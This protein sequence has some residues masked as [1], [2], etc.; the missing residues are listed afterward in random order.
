MR[1]Y[2]SFL[3]VLLLSILP[4]TN[5][6]CQV[7]GLQ[8]VNVGIGVYINQQGYCWPGQS[9]PAP[10]IQISDI[11]LLMDCSDWYIDLYE[12]EFGTKL[13]GSSSKGKYNGYNTFIPV[14]FNPSIETTPGKMYTLVPRGSGTWYIDN[15]N[16]YP[17]GRLAGTSPAGGC[18]GA[19]W[20]A[21][22]RVNCASSSQPT[23]WKCYP[24]ID[25]PLRLNAAGDVEC[26]AL[27][28]ANCLWTSSGNCEA[29][30]TG[31]MNSQLS[32]LSCGAKHLS[33]YGSPGY[34]IDAHWC[35]KG[36]GFMK[37]F[38]CIP[39]LTSPFRINAKGNPECLSTNAADCYWGTVSCTSKQVYDSSAIANIKP[40]ACGA[41][42]KAAWGRTGYEDGPEHWCNKVLAFE[43]PGCMTNG[44]VN[45]CPSINTP[46][47]GNNP[48]PLANS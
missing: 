18:W 33:L 36:W 8:D 23:A 48:C 19:Q 31:Y 17:N 6:A 2:L 4:F 42:H 43:E 41:G 46:C 27:D 25:V 45:F 35:Y 22:F 34:E 28:G 9:F 29:V 10:G 5:A 20:D 32:P 40:L 38:Y 47:T 13:L 1:Q 21:A 7:D 24:G 44:Q 15:T 11:S 16:R 3:F 37:P 26:M 14:Y 39:G 30:R 12:G